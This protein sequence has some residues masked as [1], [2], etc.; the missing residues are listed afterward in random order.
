MG[1]EVGMGFTWMYNMIF[2]KKI[3][4]GFPGSLVVKTSFHCRGCRFI[5]GQ[6]AETPHA[7]QPKKPKQ[8]KTPNIKQKQHCNKFNQDFLNGPH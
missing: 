4:R 2:V 1:Q 5:P 7:S 3:K 6:G 8:N